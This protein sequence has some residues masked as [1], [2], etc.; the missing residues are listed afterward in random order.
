MKDVYF[1][2]YKG[3]ILGIFLEK[4]DMLDFLYSLYESANYDN[5]YLDWHKVVN[6]AVADGCNSITII[7]EGYKI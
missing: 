3:N 5:E 4:V 6:G 7:T 1:V 2:L